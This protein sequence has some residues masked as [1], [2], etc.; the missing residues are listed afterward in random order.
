MTPT[1]TP[2]QINDLR[3]DMAMEASRNERANRPV[4]WVVVAGVCLLVM[5]AWLL[6]SAAARMGA[7][8]DLARQRTTSGEMLQLVAELQ[9]LEKAAAERGAAELGKP[10][11]DMRTRIGR[12][13]TTAGMKTEP[14]P[15]TRTEGGQPGVVRQRL[16]Y[17]V[18]DESLASIV[19]WL[20]GAVADVP[21][22]EVYSVR[23]KPEPTQWSVNVVFTRWERTPGT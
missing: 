14:V 16:T 3:Q 4:S 10:L 6:K 8:R 1:L 7:D 13:A 20:H 22:L 18:K 15:S 21:G 9:Q 2:Q 5:L 23:L 17:D 12:A 11:P 19:S